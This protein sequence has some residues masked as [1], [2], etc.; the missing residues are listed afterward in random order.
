[1]AIKIINPNSTTSMTEAMLRTARQAAPDLVFDGWTSTDGPPAIQGEADGT[2]AT[3]PLLELV[4]QAS[5]DGAEGIIIGCFDDTGLVAAAARA[6]CPVIGI[7]QA[8]YHFAALRH[9]RFS[10]VTTLGVS[11]PVLE[12]NIAALGLGAYLARV[13]A[14]EVPVLAL[15]SDPEAASRAIMAEAV[16]AASED[17]IDALILGCAG[18]VHVVADVTGA[19]DIEVIDPV[20]CAARSF[21]WLT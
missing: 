1:M 17:G 21:A 15:E 6:A 11:V 20:A 16:T 3:P 7:G 14:S 10:V 12:G 9:W 2:R 19:L 18:M 13:R 5:D 4:A 8:A